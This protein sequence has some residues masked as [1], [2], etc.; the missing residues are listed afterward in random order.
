[1]Q[2][3]NRRRFLQ[4]AGMSAASLALAPLTASAQTFTAG[5][6]TL[7][8]LP[9]DYDALTPA[10]SAEIMTLHHDKHHQTYVTN[11][12]AAIKDYP[13]LQKK[14]P[15]ELLMNLKEVPD[16]IRTAVNNHGGGHVNHTF[17]WQMMAPP[18]KGGEPSKP[19]TTAIDAEFGSV[20]KLKTAMSE[21]A[22][23]VFGSGWAWLVLDGSKKVKLVTTPNQNSPFLEKQTPL[24]GID[25]WEH[26]YYLQY[27]QAHDYIKAWWSVVNWKH[28]SELFGS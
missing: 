2:P 11:Y 23:K 12:N 9:Y 6:Q 26:A 8:K 28:V 20:D 25:V 24:L 5:I 15:V 13:D 22:T 4:I 27:K 18:G 1:M 19:L 21:A 7:P 14:T 17:F 3:L 10:I 16:K